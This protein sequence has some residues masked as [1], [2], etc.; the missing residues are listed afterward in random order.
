MKKNQ[1]KLKTINPKL[2]LFETEIFKINSSKELNSF[3]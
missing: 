2:Y 3:L 1:K